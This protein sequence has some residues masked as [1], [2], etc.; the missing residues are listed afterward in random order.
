MERENGEVK[1]EE[2]K[3][4]KKLRNK[5]KNLIWNKMFINFIQKYVRIKYMIIWQGEIWCRQ[6]NI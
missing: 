4:E 5:I 6:K 1:T 2:T 3:N